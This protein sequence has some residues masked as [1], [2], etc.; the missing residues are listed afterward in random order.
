MNQTIDRKDGVA[1]ITR[2]V[3]SES[4]T[5][6]RAPLGL[7]TVAIFEFAKGMIVLL[8]GL[9]LL[10]LIH[11]DAQ[12]VAEDIVRRLHLNPAHQYPRIF[13]DF[14]GHLTDARLWFMS[15]S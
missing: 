7:R 11:H 2:Q 15:L 3:K 5:H 1:T 9:G 13:I 12:A 8:A 6:H 4:G 14:A 10:S